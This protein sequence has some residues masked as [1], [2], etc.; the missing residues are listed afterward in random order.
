MIITVTITV[1]HGSQTQLVVWASF[2]KR[3]RWQTHS[4]LWMKKCISYKQQIKLQL[5]LV[6][7][8]NLLTH[9]IH[10]HKKIVSLFW[11]LTFGKFLLVHV[12]HCRPQIMSQRAVFGPC[13]S[14]M[15]KTPAVNRLTCSKSCIELQKWHLSV[16]NGKSC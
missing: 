5:S 9:S 7:A 11:L 10:C 13:P 4:F 1:K 15:C 6:Y 12:S 2:D 8:M 3:A 16:S 14:C